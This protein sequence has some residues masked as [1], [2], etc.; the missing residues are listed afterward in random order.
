MIILPNSLVTSDA[1][2]NHTAR[3]T[4]RSDVYIGIGYNDDI[5]QA[6]QIIMDI[7]DASPDIHSDPAPT[8]VVHEL[9]DSSVNLR[10]RFWVNTEIH[11]QIDF[12]ILEDAKKAFDTAGITIPYP[13]REITMIET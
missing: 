8:I 1:I 9:A 3:R 5:D 10:I 12:K 13:Q 11:R 7:L 6:R 4:R 2:I